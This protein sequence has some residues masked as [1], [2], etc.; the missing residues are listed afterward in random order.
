MVHILTLYNLQYCKLIIVNACSM[1]LV[2]GETVD[3]SLLH[4]CFAQTLLVLVLGW[5]GCS[6][7]FLGRLCNSYE[8]WKLA[9]GS[10]EG[11]INWPVSFVAAIWVLWKERSKRR[12]E[13]SSSLLYSLVDMCKFLVVLWVSILPQFEGFP[14]STMIRN[15]EEVSFS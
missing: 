10:A 2:D 7:V 9:V 12:F 4:I 5:F 6:W 8:A 1:C 3:H 14:V 13:R 15:L 11:R